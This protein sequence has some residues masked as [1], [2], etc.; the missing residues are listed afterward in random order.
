MFLVTSAVL[1]IKDKL[2]LYLRLFLSFFSYYIYDYTT[3]VGTVLFLDTR[4]YHLQ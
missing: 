4:G 2:K 3:V 1:P